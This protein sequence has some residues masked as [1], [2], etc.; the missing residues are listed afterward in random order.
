MRGDAAPAAQDDHEMF[1][2]SYT[3]HGDHSGWTANDGQRSAVVWLL[4]H[5]ACS[6]A[7]AATLR[8]DAH[9]QAVQGD[10][11]PAFGLG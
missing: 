4:E 9:A 7:E 2:D 10:L 8:H 3:D 1:T 6:D 11:F 5:D